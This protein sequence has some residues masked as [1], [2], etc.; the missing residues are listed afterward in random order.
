[1]PLSYTALGVMSYPFLFLTSLAFSLSLSQVSAKV[2]VQL[3]VANFGRFLIFF[4]K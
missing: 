1:M 2:K 3:R 4:F